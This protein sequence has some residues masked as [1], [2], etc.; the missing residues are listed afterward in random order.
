[1]RQI[2]P[3]EIFIHTRR[4]DEPTNSLAIGEEDAEHEHNGNA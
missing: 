3:K 4:A 2:R 1:M